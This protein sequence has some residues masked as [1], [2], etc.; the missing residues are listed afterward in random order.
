MPITV[1]FLLVCGPMVGGFIW[2]GL[3]YSAFALETWLEDI[4]FLYGTDI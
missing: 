4:T 2:L 1:G 3:A